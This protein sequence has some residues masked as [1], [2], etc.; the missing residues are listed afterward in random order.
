[1]A[2]SLITTADEKGLEAELFR[3]DTRSC[4]STPPSRDGIVASCPTLVAPQGYEH[5]YC[6][7]KQSFPQDSAWESWIHHWELVHL[8]AGALLVFVRV[9]IPSACTKLGIFRNHKWVSKVV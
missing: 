5:Y 1:M 3:R 8:A 6:F 4:D 9:A 7:L 2:P